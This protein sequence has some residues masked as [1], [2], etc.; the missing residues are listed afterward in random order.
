MLL[1]MNK[2]QKIADRIPAIQAIHQHPGWNENNW[3]YGQ[4]SAFAGCKQLRTGAP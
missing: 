4:E 2:R 3:G 1:H